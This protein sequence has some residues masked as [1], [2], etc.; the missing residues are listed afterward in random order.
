M[1]SSWSLYRGATRLLFTSSGA[2]TM[3]RL[4]S[5]FI[6]P[7]IFS[8][9]LALTT[10][11]MG[12]SP[13]LKKR[14]A[15]VITDRAIR[16][17]AESLLPTFRVTGFDVEL[18]DKAQPEPPVEVVTEIAEDMARFEP[19][20]VVAVG[21][22]SAIDTAKA[23]WLK[24]ERP[25]MD[26][27]AAIPLSPIGLRSKAFLMAIPTTAGTGSEATAAFVLTDT[28]EDPP[29]KVV[30]AHVELVPDFAV[31]IPELT[32]EM[33]RELTI[34]TGLDALAH[35]FEA[36]INRN[37][38]NPIT[39]SLAL[40]AMK[41]IFRYLPLAVDEPR[42]IEARYKML[43]AATMA[44]LAF[45]NAGVG[46]THALGHALGKVFGLHHGKV[47]GIMI[48]YVLNYLARVTDAYVEL[49][50]ELGVECKD[51]CLE[52]L[53]AH[54]VNFIESFD[55]PIALKEHVDA[56]KFREELDVLTKYAYEDPTVLQSMRQPGLEEI[57]RLFEYAFEGRMP[58]W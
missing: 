15:F 47:V 16:K 44:G 8:G 40:W 55:V 37:W 25:D 12:I 20:L 58:D 28:S 54:F 50:R 36:F 29:R 7:R 31:L 52:K 42:N 11:L 6:A 38:A 23:A 49:A 5:F 51:D 4:Q 13:L 43:V 18:C 56:E 53:T 35:A 57:R 45:S 30:H 3:R 33:P 14:R 22:G 24:Y 39:D 9:S 41:T 32:L 19:D 21:G 48:P 17:L 2:R 26:L 27:G 1:A 10:A 34:G 46:L